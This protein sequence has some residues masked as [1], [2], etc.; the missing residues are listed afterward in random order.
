MLAVLNMLL[1]DSVMRI[2]LLILFFS[3]NSF[4]QDDAPFEAKLYSIE[5][6]REGAFTT[7]W[8]KAGEGS[9]R[10]NKIFIKNLPDSVATGD[11]WSGNLQRS[12]AH[13]LKDG[14]KIPEFS[15][16]GTGQ[17]NDTNDSTIKTISSQIASTA[18]QGV[19]K[20]TGE[21]YYK[22]TEVFRNAANT[23]ITT[24]NSNE[25]PITDEVFMVEAGS[26]SGTGFL[27]N[28]NSKVYFYSNIHVFRKTE[29]A[30][31]RNAKREIL[32]IPKIIELAEGE[33]L[34][35][36]STDRTS[37]LSLGDSPQ[38][39]EVVLAVGNS[40]GSGVITKNSGEILGI[41]DSIFE[42]SCEIVP[43]N[44]GGPITDK[45]GRVYGVASFLTL[46]DDDLATEGTRYSK[47]RRFGIKINRTLNWESVDYETFRK[48]AK[49]INAINESLQAVLDCWD[50]IDY[51][52]AMT[53]FKV[54]KDLP[55]TSRAQAKL[56]NV[57]RYHNRE[58]INPY[59]NKSSKEMWGY[60]NTQLKETCEVIISE[61]RASLNSNWGKTEYEQ[62]KEWATRLAK[63]IATHR[64]KV[65]KSF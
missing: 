58:Y 54:S 44:S 39:G 48:E 49:F 61:N 11:D 52:K 60:M 51:E 24:E 56:D 26:S 13:T 16:A 45:R 34:L 5:A 57:V 31:L 18:L 47:T 22:A 63:A 62:S 43:G 35:R 27:L 12:G 3:F 64:E 25:A 40:S 17:G 38:L 7:K 55:S 2:V 59:G 10:T 1:K 15:V 19:E 28:N 6:S 14:T 42:V 29:K 33:D 46:G 20:K 37:G 4:A 21:F 36:F 30:V 41:G 53:S 65:R 32:E 9:T 8:E 50:S 23:V